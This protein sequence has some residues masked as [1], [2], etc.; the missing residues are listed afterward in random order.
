MEDTCTHCGNLDEVGKWITQFG[1]EGELP[2]RII[3]GETAD[4]VDGIL[5]GQVVS[6][7]MLPDEHSLYLGEIVELDELGLKS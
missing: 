7:E 2:F 5:D 3:P 1:G 6:I 4:F